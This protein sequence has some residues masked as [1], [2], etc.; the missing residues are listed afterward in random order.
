MRNRFGGN[1]FMFLFY[2]DLKKIGSCNIRVLNQKLLVSVSVFKLLHR[3][4]SSNY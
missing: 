3:S 1:L 2:L 4:D